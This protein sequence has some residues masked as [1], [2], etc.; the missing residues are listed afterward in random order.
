MT[1]SIWWP[2]SALMQPRTSLGKSGVS[3]RWMDPIG[4]P[5]LPPSGPEGDG[6]LQ[7]LATEGSPRLDAFNAQDC[8]KF[9]YALAKRRVPRTSLL[10]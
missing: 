4:V 7:A 1:S 9:L 2:K 3:R 10:P 8:S 5:R 6:C